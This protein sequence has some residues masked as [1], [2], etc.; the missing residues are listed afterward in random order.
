[1]AQVWIL[2]VLPFIGLVVVTSLVVGMLG[3]GQY[4]F[5]TSPES[6]FVNSTCFVN[7]SSLLSFSVIPLVPGYTSNCGITTEDC[8]GVKWQ[9]IVNDTDQ[10]E[11]IYSSGSS[12]S[13]AQ[14]L[15]N[16]YQV[17]Y[18]YPC[19]YI[20]SGCC[21]VSW[22]DWSPTS[23]DINRDIS[24]MTAGFATSFGCVMV[25]AILVVVYFRVGE[26]KQ[27]FYSSDA[28]YYYRSGSDKNM[29]QT[30]SSVKRFGNHHYESVMQ[31]PTI[32]TSEEINRLLDS[33]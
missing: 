10:T 30:S 7:Q 26:E 4:H 14:N 2:V 22:E 8:Y 9:V 15:F 16:I 17:G 28:P 20:V 1:M 19:W 3:L 25:L 29:L 32:G 12:H 33:R 24:V 11:W 5:D 6:G 23:Q 18:T 27:P 13:W 21:V 31:S